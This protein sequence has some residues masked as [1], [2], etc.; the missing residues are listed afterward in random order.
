MMGSMLYL[1]V[2]ISLPCVS[3][4][5]MVEGTNDKVSNLMVWDVPL[6]ITWRCLLL[7]RFL[8]GRVGAGWVDAGWVLVGV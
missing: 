7:E 6:K 4:N 8:V 3:V 5:L 1:D 2:S